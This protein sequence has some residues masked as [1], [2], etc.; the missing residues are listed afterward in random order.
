MKW[1]LDYSGEV[2]SSTYRQKRTENL[3]LST[4]PYTEIPTPTRTTKGLRI[5]YCKVMDVVL[6]V[7]L[8]VALASHHITSREPR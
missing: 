5:R 7:V 2:A 3:Y 6:E 8:E 1:M 4:Y